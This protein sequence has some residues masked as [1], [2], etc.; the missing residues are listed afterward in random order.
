MITKQ[1]TDKAE[2]LGAEAGKNQA[3]WYF[4]GN[5]DRE[6]YEEFLRGSE[7]GDPAVLDRFVAPN[8]ENIYDNHDEEFLADVGYTGH[9]YNDVDTLSDYFNSASNDNMFAELERIA[10]GHFTEHH[11]NLDDAYT[12]SGCRGV[13]WVLESSRAFDG[14]IPAHMVG[15]D[16][17]EEIPVED[18][19]RLDPGDFCAVCGQTGHNCG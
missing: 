5:T 13:A 11:L 12:V 9:D 10:A 2:A 3:G 8:V 7:A 6:T 14:M 1:Q 15:D 16:R 18:F 17:T 4:D 19:T